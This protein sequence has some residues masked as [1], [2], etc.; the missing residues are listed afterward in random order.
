MR[1]ILTLILTIIIL[2][3][4]GVAGLLGY[5]LMEGDAP[6]I[7][8]VPDIEAMGGEAVISVEV[9]DKG[10]GLKRI[11]G[12]LIQGNKEVRLKPTYNFK[13]LAWWKGTGFGSY[14]VA[15]KVEPRKLGLRDGSCTIR[16]EAE[17]AS[18]RHIIKGNISRLEKVVQID[19]VPPVIDVLSSVHNIRRGG[20]G[21]VAFRLNEPVY[22]AGVRVSDSIFFKAFPY[23]AKN[24]YLCLIALP[25]DY[26]GSGSMFIEAYDPAGNKGMAGFAHRVLGRRL[27]EDTIPI[28]QGF[29]QRKMPDF[30]TF[31]PD[32]KDDYKS[33]FLKVNS[34]LRARNNAKLKEV[35]SSASLG[36]IQWKGRFKQLPN[37]I[38]RAGFADHRTYLYR[39]KKIDEAFH[40]GLD[41][42]SLKR[43]EVPASNDG[44]VIFADYLGI[45]GNTVVIDHGLGLCSTYSHLSEMAVKV[46][47]PVKKGDIIGK[48]GMTGLAGGDH[49]HFGMLV[50]G[51]FVDPLEWLDAK[52]IQEHIVVN[53]PPQ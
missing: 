41:L 20:A 47:D 27:V 9:R 44:T 26:S 10:T 40:M 31:F 15:W 36:T 23:G 12:W 50:R 51:V 35:C 46:G 37:S 2:A 45:Y 16:I 13:R 5:T 28:S 4:L 33:L 34:E 29:L 48:T 32:L 22:K 1:R 19:T 11:Q 8:L 30:I 18:Y 21:L 24:T 39:G 3:A 53:I 42:A 43:A 38:K 52:W 6:T 17:D 49:L 14:P 25:F 7:A